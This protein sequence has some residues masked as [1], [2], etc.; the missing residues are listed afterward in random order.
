MRRALHWLSL[1]VAAG[2]L[3]PAGCASDSPAGCEGITGSEA[4]PAPTATELGSAVPCSGAA[5]WGACVAES[6]P[7]VS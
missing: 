3:L 2:A 5:T 7:A 6:A 4:D 1:L